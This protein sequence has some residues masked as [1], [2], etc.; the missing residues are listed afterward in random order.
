MFKD[1]SQDRDRVEVVVLDA[2]FRQA[3]AQREL[4][5]GVEFEQRKERNCFWSLSLACDG[6]LQVLIQMAE[7]HAHRGGARIRIGNSSGIRAEA[8]RLVITIAFVRP[9]FVSGYLLESDEIRQPKS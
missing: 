2:L 9:V 4:G 7:S 6:N 1:L 3:Q 8:R 5:F